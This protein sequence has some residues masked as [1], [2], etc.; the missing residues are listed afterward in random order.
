MSRTSTA[1]KRRYNSKV[2]ER[3]S[4]DVPKGTKANWKEHAES[5]GK[6][7]TQFVREAVEEAI[8]RA[9]SSR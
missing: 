6:S 7:L 8:E 9:I 1:V 5:K 2:Y 4:L 3:I